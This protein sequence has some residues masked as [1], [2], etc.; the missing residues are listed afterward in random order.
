MMTE[1]QIEKLQRLLA[2][3]KVCDDKTAAKVAELDQRIL[4]LSLIHI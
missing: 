4:H 1:K 2:D 3:N